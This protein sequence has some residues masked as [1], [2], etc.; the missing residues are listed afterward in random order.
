M[1]DL[2]TQAVTE[3]YGRKRMKYEMGMQHAAPH[4]YTC[5]EVIDFM[6]NIES[7]EDFDGAKVDS[8]KNTVTSLRR[9]PTRTPRLEISTACS[10]ARAITPLRIA[11]S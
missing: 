4:P 3:D 5:K 8:S 2:I 10:M 1:G 7:S 6:E 11:T 9:A